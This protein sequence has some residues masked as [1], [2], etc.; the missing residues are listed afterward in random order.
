MNSYTLL[1]DP[2]LECDAVD[3]HPDAVYNGTCP[4]P[5]GWTP[6]PGWEEPD[7][8]SDSGVAPTEPQPTNSETDA[9]QP[10]PTGSGGPGDT[11]TTATVAPPATT[12]DDGS[13]PITG[14]SLSGVIG[15]GVGLVLLGVVVLVW[16]RRRTRRA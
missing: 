16:L 2:T 11:H 3:P 9:G 1:V 7:A 14:A 15:A 5:P 13:L 8:D 4:A 12:H 10:S 6:P